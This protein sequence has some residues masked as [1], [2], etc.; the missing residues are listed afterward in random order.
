MRAA[1]F[2]A[3]ALVLAGAAA[4][5]PLAFGSSDDP[6]E[7]GSA[8]RPADRARVG[9]LAG[10]AYL[11]ASWR[12]AASVDLDASVGRLSVGLGQTVHS[13]A[14]G[15]YGPEADEPYDLARA[16]RYVRWNAT[17]GDRTYA[18]LGPTDRVTLGVG[19]LVRRYRTT[20]AWDE[21]TLGAEAAVETRG[22][23]AAGFVDDVLRLDGVVGG[24]V[25]VRSG[26]GLGP[27]RALALTVGAVHD[28]GRSGLDGDSSLTGVE[29]TLKGD[30]T[31]LGPIV[32]RPFLTHA[33]Y[34]GQGG[35]VG[36]GAE[37][38]ASNIGDAARARF[39]AGVFVSSAGFVPGHVGPFYAISNG[40][41][42]I[43]DD[44]TFYDAATPDQLAGTPLDSLSAGVDVMLDGRIVAFGRAEVS[45]HF[46]RHVGDERASGFG[47]R[48]A[49]RLPGDGRVEFGLERQDFRG[50]F[51]LVQDLGAVNAL[52]LD[53]RVPVGGRGLVFV[54]SRYGYRRLTE[55]DGPAYADGPGR[56]LVERRFEPLVGL[57]VGG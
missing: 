29:V 21:R 24:E 40:D 19:A 12:A 27:V 32:V 38:G 44:R 39:R 48:L 37:V 16:V 55:A 43:V 52:V 17:T 4:A 50:V 3:L 36:G 33:R 30:Y 5:Q 14:G 6:L 22:L 47:V 51:D 11:P 18:R 28:L 31:G 2:P 49:G 53:I 20:T 54:R 23:R 7:W 42:R 56:F 41:E 1:L 13:G 35:T 34:L 15:L 10:P 25:G 8:L 26:L 57:R 46:R 9:V 45:A